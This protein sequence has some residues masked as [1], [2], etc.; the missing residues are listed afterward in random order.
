MK[1]QAAAIAITIAAFS[2]TAP[3]HAGMKLTRLGENHYILQQVTHTG[4]GKSTKILRTLYVEAASLCVAL[5]FEH[6]ETRGNEI[7]PES[8]GAT[9]RGSM[10]VRSLHEKSAEKIR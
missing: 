3:A 10:E 7:S 4:F 9:A 2:L 1:K 5:D 6:F 8:P